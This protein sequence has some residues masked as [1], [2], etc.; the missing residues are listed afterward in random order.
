[1]YFE[2]LMY[3]LYTPLSQYIPPCLACAHDGSA[4]D[5][6]GAQREACAIYIFA[7]QT[8]FNIDP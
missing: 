7:D 1:M 3:H 6:A 2:M 4:D 8:E 5:V